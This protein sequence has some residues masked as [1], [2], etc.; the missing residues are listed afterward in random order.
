MSISKA[1]RHRLFDPYTGGVLSVG[2]RARR[3]EKFHATFPDIGEMK[4]LDLGGRPEY[5]ITAPVRPKHVTCVNLD[6]PVTSD[7]QWIE[8]VCGDACVPIVGEFDLVVSNSLLE[9]VGGHQSRLRLAEAV[10]SSADRYWVQTPYRYFPIEPHWLFPGM[11]WLPHRAR[12]E[13]S[14][15]WSFGHVQT[16]TREA[17]EDRVNEVDLVGIDQMRGY[18]PDADIWYERMAGLVKSLVAIKV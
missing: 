14:L 1:I 3:W 13:V 8:Y 15:R 9:H 10:R 4:V 5:W 17:A 2:A 12:V 16:S 6:Q 7:V 11:Q 18:F